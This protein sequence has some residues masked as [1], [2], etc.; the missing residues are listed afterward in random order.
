MDST[1]LDGQE[2][3]MSARAR[4]GS[5]RHGRQLRSHPANQ[6]RASTSTSTSGNCAI[7]GLTMTV[8][9]HPRHRHRH[10]QLHLRPDWKWRQGWH[11]CSISALSAI[12]LVHIDHRWRKETRTSGPALGGHPH[13]PPVQSE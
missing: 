12:D 13:I 10:R 6:V 3:S 2:L 8:L 5:R 4:V 11:D 9:P 7:G 1:A